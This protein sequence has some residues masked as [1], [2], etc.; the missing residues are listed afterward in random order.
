MKLPRYVHGFIDRHGRPRHYFRRLGFKKVPLPGTPWSPEF[1]ATYQDALAGQPPAIGARHVLP[2]SMR[3]LAVSYYNSPDYLKMSSKSVRRN[4][5]EKFLRESDANGQSNGDKRAAMLRKEHVISF[6][7]AR[8]DKPESANGLC[9]AL[10]ALMQHAVAIKLR[11]D[12]P[13]QCVKSIPAKSKTG[14]HTW[15]EAEIARFEAHHPIGS[16]PRLALAL[17]LYT[18]QARQDAIA[19]G[20]QHIRQDVLHWVR[21]KTAHTTAINLF[22]P[23]LAQLRE[24]LD[25][26]SSGHLTFLVTEFGKPFTAAGFG[27]WFRA[28]CD[29]A[30]LPHCRITGCERARHGAWRNTG[31]RRMRSQRLPATRR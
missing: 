7:A 28:Q 17:G 1:M 25:A 2:G 8:A 12:D 15:T 9:K 29:E 18:G 10:R 27:G 21:K 14:F 20:P 31:A 3:A 24:I 19:M 26:N 22:I 6:M 11:T 13:T 30:G 4:I 5:I 23:V 16:K